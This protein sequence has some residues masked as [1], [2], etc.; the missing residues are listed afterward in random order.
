MIEAFELGYAPD[1]WDGLAKTI[2]AKGWSKPDFELA[3]VIKARQQGDGHFDFLR[4]RLVFPIL[5]GFGT[6][7]RL[8][9]TG[10]ARRRRPQ[11]PQ[12]AR[13]AAV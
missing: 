4:H 5:D 10:V 11:V 3:Q 9:R 8:W 7:H 12:L 6:P 2:D 13:N 1:G